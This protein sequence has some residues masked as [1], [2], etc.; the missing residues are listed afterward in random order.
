MKQIRPINN[1]SKE[2]WDQ[3]YREVETLQKARHLNIVPLL[4][5]YFL[6]TTDS[7]DRLIRTMY[8]LFP[9]AEMD[10]ATWM[11][12]SQVPMPLQDSSRSE[13]QAYI[14]RSMYALVSGMSYLHR[15]NE[16]FITS[17]HD[18]KPSNILVI[19]QDFK[20][21]DLGRS[22]LRPA[23]GGSETE[24]AN[25]LGTYEYQPPE[26]WQ[27]NGSRTKL[28]HGRAFDIWAMGCILIELATL[29]VDDWEPEQVSRF[30]Q[31]RA[32]NTT[33]D[34]PD[35]AKSRNDD[36][37]SFHNNWSI[38]NN[39]VTQL[40]QHPRSS[41]TL[42]DTLDVAMAMLVHEPGSRLYSWEAE[43]D[44][45]GIQNPGLS[46]IT[47]DGGPG[48]L[49]VQPQWKSRY[50]ESYVNGMQTP[51][52]RAALKADRRRMMALLS[53][54][55]HMSVQDQN[56]ET[57]LDIIRRSADKYFR[58]SFKSYLGQGVTA[59]NTNQGFAL[60]QA[61]ET[62]DTLAMKTLLEA[63]ANPM[64][65]NSEGRSPLFL[66][67]TNGH[68]HTIKSL[69]QVHADEQLLLKDRL[70]G[71]VALHQAVLTNR[72]DVLKHILKYSP[73]L[74][75]RQREGK[76]ALF[77]AVQMNCEE[78]VKALLDHGPSAR[79]FTQCN[80]GNTPVHKAVILNNELLQLLLD[81]EDSARCLEHK[82]QYGETPVWLALR[83]GRFEAFRVL[84]ERGASLRV[85]NNDHDNLLHLV[86]RQRL[87]DFLNQN[88]H[89]F[90]ASDIEGRNRWNDTPL[91]IADRNGHSEIAGL[92]RSYYTGTVPIS[93]DD[94]GLGDAPSNH[95]KLFYTLGSEPKWIR[96][97]SEGYWRHLTYDSYQVYERI[98]LQARN[99]QNGPLKCKQSM[100]LRPL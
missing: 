50:H 100:L 64:L 4:A 17:H 33:P 44:L 11:T 68:L 73:D 14:Y 26:Y 53:S 93:A 77:L 52:H 49:C 86:A 83:H 97:D 30:R 19:G 43:L 18:L 91:T 56:G 79:V 63:G 96:Q 20:I 15:E 95:P 6:D 1:D 10:L 66:A 12:C 5:S 60:L 65:V 51:L 41:T 92:L 32:D 34:R 55:W 2:E 81:A 3:L 84:K 85:A 13:R 62:D 54:G 88:L 7:S 76:T 74:E 75:D 94:L 28:R 24:G 57:A 16:G 99:Q 23:D 98:Y 78:M 31:E 25:G 8:L 46:Q 70:K 9:W 59:T 40:K 80:T 42:E 47:S 82:N 69:L 72:L 35:L 58:E 38:V 36:D 27:D 37:S 67:V 71:Y 39:W 22:H 90:D 87:Y 61:A 29:I 21:A 48:S 89:A 45:Y